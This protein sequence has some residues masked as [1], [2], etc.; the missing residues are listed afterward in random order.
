MSHVT[1]KTVAVL[2]KAWIHSGMIIF[3][4]AYRNLAGLV[5]AINPLKSKGEDD[6]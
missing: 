4:T 5:A 1:D 2:A 3:G 6:G